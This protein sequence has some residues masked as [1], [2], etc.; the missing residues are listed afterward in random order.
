[1]ELPLEIAEGLRREGA[2]EVR[3]A[4]EEFGVE[5][6]EIRDHVNVCQLR[7]E[8]C[9]QPG[10]GGGGGGGGGAPPAAGGPAGGGRGGGGGGGG[11]GRGG[12]APPG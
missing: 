7:E 8:R 11:G 5:L 2:A 1:M 3:P 10:G 9:S 4:R 6:G 12:G